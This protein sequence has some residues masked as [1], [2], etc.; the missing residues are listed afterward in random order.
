M[1]ITTSL[2]SKNSYALIG[3][4]V[5][6]L[7][8]ICFMHYHGRITDAKMY[9]MFKGLRL[10]FIHTFSFGLGSP[11]YFPNLKPK[12]DEKPLLRMVNT[13]HNTIN[14]SWYNHEAMY[15]ILQDTFFEVAMKPEHKEMS[16]DT[17]MGY[18][19]KFLGKNKRSC[20]LFIEN[21][22]IDK[23]YHIFEYDFDKGVD[24]FKEM[25]LVASGSYTSYYNFS[26]S[27][28]CCDDCDGD[29]ETYKKGQ[30]KHYVIDRMMEDIKKQ[31]TN[32]KKKYY[33]IY[34]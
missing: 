18:L 2:I 25:G 27:G 10:N 14:D 29:Y 16:L 9:G 31:L 7:L 4:E 3:N 28:Y 24:L 19:N 12:R 32:N 17:F 13:Y 5:E 34:K 11:V 6:A 30:Y 21:E 33:E 1:K 23:V 26:A 22:I 20:Y 8:M 15:T